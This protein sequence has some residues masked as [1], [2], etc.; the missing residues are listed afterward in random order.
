MFSYCS[1]EPIM[2][3]DE[4][5]YLWNLVAG[6]VIGGL[7]SGITSAVMQYKQ[8]GSI[9]VKTLLI[10]TV[11]GAASG[12]LAASGFGFP[13]QILGN[14]LISGSS[15]AADNAVNG[16]R[17]KYKDFTANVIIGGASGLFGGRGLMS[18]KG[19]LKPVLD[20]AEKSVA[21]D[22]RRANTKYAWKSISRTCENAANVYRKESFKSVVRY[23]G[24]FAASTGILYAY[25]ELSTPPGGGCGR[26][27]Q[28]MIS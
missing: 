19:A 12:A 14:A 13:G 16:N 18:R 25:G 17:F 9:N 7:I 21:K 3:E 24:S 23:T 5:G 20:A 22:L 28:F 27:C 15:Y 2:R 6:A 4:G 10:N 1:N 8:T 26:P 11:A